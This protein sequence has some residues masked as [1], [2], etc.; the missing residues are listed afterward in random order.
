MTQVWR[1]AMRQARA[2]ATLTGLRRSV[3]GSRTISGG[4]TYTAVIAGSVMERLLRES[5]GQR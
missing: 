4:W 3:V 1:E 5:R 2:G